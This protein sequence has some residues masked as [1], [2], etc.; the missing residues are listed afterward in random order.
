[1]DYNINM[2]TM[3]NEMRVNDSAIVTVWSISE[4][5]K[6][7]NKTEEIIIVSL[8]SCEYVDHINC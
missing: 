2:S 3:I 5:T 8:N 6:N 4:E 7:D 1:M